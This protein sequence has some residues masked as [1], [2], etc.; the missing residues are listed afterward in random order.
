MKRGEI[1]SVSGAAGYGSKPRPT[2]VVQSDKFAGTKSVITCGLTTVV[3]EAL[4]RPVIE[5]TP[6][7]GLHVRSSV[8]IE[9]LIAVPREKAGERI[10]Q[11]SAED[12]ARVEDAMLLV[13]GFAG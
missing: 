4:F 2:L 3:I 13:L 6:D 9:K 11:L 7:N 12:L 10:G 8:M 1:W 5:P